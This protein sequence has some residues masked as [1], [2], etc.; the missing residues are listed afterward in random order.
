MSE[1]DHPDMMMTMDQDALVTTE[2]IR[3]A[4]VV[5]SWSLSDPEK[6]SHDCEEVRRAREFLFAWWERKRPVLEMPKL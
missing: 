5:V 4:H 3:A 1:N 6:I 2:L